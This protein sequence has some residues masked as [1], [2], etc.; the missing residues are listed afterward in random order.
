MLSSL[1]NNSN[2]KKDDNEIDSQNKNDNKLINQINNNTENTENK[3]DDIKLKSNL[4]KDPLTTMNFSNNN[5]N[6]ELEGFDNI[7]STCYM[8]SFLQIILHTPG[9]LL[10]LKKSKMRKTLIINLLII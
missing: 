5:F 3:F 1:N 6:Q 10:E 8:N 2:I 9:F 4:S 7:G